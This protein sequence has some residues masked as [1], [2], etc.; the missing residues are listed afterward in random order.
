[1]K[2]QFNARLTENTL[3]AI[4]VAAKEW[5]CTEAEVIERWA[6]QK[7]QI[8]VV[9]PAISANDKKAM[10]DAL[11]ATLSGNP[12]TQ[13]L[14]FE[15]DEPEEPEGPSLPFD[16]SVDG[17]PH[18]IEQNGKRVSLFCMSSGEPVFIRNL[19]DGEW[20]KLW[21]KRIA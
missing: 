3:L 11:K 19:N 15:T 16:L 20:R 10:F 5:N 12:H 17:E 1:M 2:K 4:K 8:T 13:P 18:R 14:S 6:N 7:P 21:E 9:A